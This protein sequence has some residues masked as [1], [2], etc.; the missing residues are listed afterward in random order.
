M[1]VKALPAQYRNNTLRVGVLYKLMLMIIL[2][3][4]LPDTVL[5]QYTSTEVYEKM[6]AADLS[7]T[8]NITLKGRTVRLPDRY[9]PGLGAYGMRF[10]FTQNTDQRAIA[11]VATDLPEIK[12]IPGHME[13]FAPFLKTWVYCGPSA[14]GQSHI[15]GSDD[16]SDS[17]ESLLNTAD[18]ISALI[19]I[20]SPT[21]T[22]GLY[23]IE[24]LRA[25]GRGFTTDATACTSANDKGEGVIAVTLTTEY[26]EWSLLV[27]PDNEY[28]AREGNFTIKGDTEPSIHMKNS[29]SIIM[30]V[31][32]YA[33]YE[34]KKGTG[35]PA[36]C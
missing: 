2:N 13:R 27:E 35:V 21:G 23:M 15:C 10:A 33:T 24:L 34:E 25:M 1:Q 18:H 20:S 17:V 29:G 31:P 16:S 3:L 19:T 5:A 12:T 4:S 8:T 32:S 6:K 14:E 30:G 9:T 26:G 22:S 11:F 28:V 36:E 7:F